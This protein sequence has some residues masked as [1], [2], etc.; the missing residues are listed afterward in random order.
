M[1][2]LAKFTQ[3]LLETS[4]THLQPVEGRLPWGKIAVGAG[5]LYLTCAVLV[6]FY[7]SQEPDP[8]DVQEYASDYARA[9]QQSLVTGSVTTATLIKLGETLL[10]KP[11]G[12]LSN[13]RFPPG[14]WLDNIPSWEFGVLVQIRDMSRALRRD[15]SR[16]QSQSSEDQDLA[17]AEPQFFF[18]SNSWILPSTESEY[19]RGLQVLGSYL[20]RLADQQQADGQF[21]ARADNLVRWLSDVESRLGSLSQRLSASVGKDQLNLALAGDTTATQSTAAPSD[22]KVK[23]PWT[24]IDNIFY[25]TRG[26]AWALIQLLRAVEIDFR[27]VLEDKNAL[28]SLRQ[29]IRELEST[30]QALWSPMVFNGSG[31]GIFANHSLVMASYI[32]RA[33]AAIIDLRELLAKG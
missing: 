10:E 33:N 12:Y 2:K 30:Q 21:Y 19:R 14:L 25:E 23:T 27:K 31:F 28:V 8:F 18:D 20:Y 26:S 7:W 1:Q 11:G 16:S 4:R 3:K 22:Q 13:D 9:Q 24:Q 29:I 15:M 17:K 5:A 6:G 32:S